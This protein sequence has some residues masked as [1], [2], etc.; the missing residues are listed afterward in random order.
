MIH[1]EDQQK[2]FI[3]IAE[4]LPKR[5]ETYAI[6][7][8]AMMFLGLKES[9][10]DVDIVFA[11]IEDRKIFKET[12][13]SL[14]FKESSAQIVYGKKDNTPEMVVL[15]DVRVDLFLFKIISSNFSEGMQKRA[16]QTH[17]FANN[18]LIKVADPADILIMKSVTSRDKDLED[19]VEIINKGRID[20]NTVVEESAE[21]VRLGNEIAIMGLGEK[22][23]RLANQGL[24]KVPKDVSDKIWKLFTKQVKEKGKRAK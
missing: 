20:W 13:K 22:L 14:G 10:P 18:L 23:E 2:L 11:N 24:I 6:G 9:T 4:K 5:I 7:G 17:E 8:T 19:I 16:T 15:L 21:Q 12:M 1:I 3:R